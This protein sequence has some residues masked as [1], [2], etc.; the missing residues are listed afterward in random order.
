VKEVWYVVDGRG[1][2]WRR[3]GLDEEVVEPV[4]HS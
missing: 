2:V 4:Q 3:G 1:E